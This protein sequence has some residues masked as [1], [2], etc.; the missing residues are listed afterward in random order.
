M[1]LLSAL[2]AC[3]AELEMCQMEAT[4]LRSK[5]STALLGPDAEALRAEV[6]AAR[7]QLS[8]AL[9]TAEHP[10]SARAYPVFAAERKQ[11]LRQ[12]SVAKE[13]E[14]RL[15]KRLRKLEGQVA[16]GG[17]EATKEVLLGKDQELRRLLEGQERCRAAEM[18]VRNALLRIEVCA[19]VGPQD[20]HPCPTGKSLTG[21]CPCTAPKCLSI[22]G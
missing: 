19:A 17:A 9:S 16:V 3:H 15:H 13:G 10:S 14:A 12:L 8:E 18:L 2:L 22:T 7:Q 11:L 6:A 1:E 20:S 5:L 4:S 21:I